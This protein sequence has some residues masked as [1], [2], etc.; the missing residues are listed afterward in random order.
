MNITLIKSIV[1]ALGDGFFGIPTD[2]VKWLA[3]LRKIES[4]PKAPKWV[5]GLI[6]YKD[7]VLPYIRLWDILNVSSPE[8]EIVLL[9]GAS[10]YLAYGIS[11][12]KGI[13]QMDVKKYDDNIIEIP[14]I[15]GYGILEERVVI[16]IDLNNFLTKK[17]T[18]VVRRIYSKNEKK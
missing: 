11:E 14:Y 2:Q 18:R 16:I 1:F 5:S 7:I 4:I 15:M 9:P 8:K 12:I 6:R 3:K 17:Q 13:Y 10:D